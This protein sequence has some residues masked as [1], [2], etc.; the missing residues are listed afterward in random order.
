MGSIESPSLDAAMGSIQLPSSLAHPISI[1]D[2]D[3]PPS[4]VLLPNSC[5]GVS[6]ELVVAH[7][8]SECLGGDTTNYGFNPILRAETL[9]IMESGR[10]ARAKLLNAM[11]G[12][13]TADTFGGTLSATAASTFNTKEDIFSDSSNEYDY[14]NDGGVDNSTINAGL[15]APLQVS[16]LV[17]PDSF[18]AVDH[19]VDAI[20]VV[21]ST[22]PNVDV[23]SDDYMN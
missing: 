23:V 16:P 20:S 22:T 8:M 1:P 17:L 13:G 2:T 3:T 10:N 12:S 21:D 7:S 18:V 9:A 6:S 5:A 19:D 14:E 11:S 4:P 15:F